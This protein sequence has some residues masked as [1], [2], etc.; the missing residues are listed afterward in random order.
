M[1]VIFVVLFALVA[2]GATCFGNDDDFD[3]EKQP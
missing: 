2:I 3:E 1:I